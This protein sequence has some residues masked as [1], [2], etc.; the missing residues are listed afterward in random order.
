MTFDLYILYKKKFMYYFIL[1]IN[2]LI[3]IITIVIIVIINVTVAAV[4]AVL[5]L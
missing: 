4:V 2:F 1:D 5:L 3:S